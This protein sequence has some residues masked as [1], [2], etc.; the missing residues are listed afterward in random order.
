MLVIS[1]LFTTRR[2]GIDRQVLYTFIKIEY[3]TW[4]TFYTITIGWVGLLKSPNLDWHAST[5]ISNLQL[6]GG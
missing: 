6:V 1:C 2:V 3:I 4:G 5:P